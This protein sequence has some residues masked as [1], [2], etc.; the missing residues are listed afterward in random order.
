MQPS[1]A[2]Y[3]GQSGKAYDHPAG[4]TALALYT[5]LKCKYPAD[6]P[7]VKKGFAWLE[8]RHARP[9]GSYETAVALLAVCATADPNKSTGVSEANKAKIREKLEELKSKK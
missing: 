2:I 9:A 3:G 5:L 7:Q 6:H 4:P 1:G 8:K